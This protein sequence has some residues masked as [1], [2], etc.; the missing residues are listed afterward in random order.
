MWV[1]AHR[2]ACK[3][4]PEN[5]LDAFQVAID[6]GA[7][8]V[9]FD[10]YQVE[11]RTIVIHD[12]WLERTT[13]GSG[14]VTAQSV[15]Y[16]RSLNAGNNEKIPFLAEVMA[17]MPSHAICNIEI[18]HLVDIN[19]WLKELDIALNQSSLNPSNLIISSFNHAWLKKLKAARPALQIGALTATYPENGP[20]FATSLQAY[21]LHM[22]LDVI[23]EGYVK[24]AQDAGLK[25]LVY[26]VDKPDDMRLLAKWGADG[27]FTNVPDIAKA[28][29]ANQ[30][31]S[32]Y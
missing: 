15:E 30:V 21:S 14:L 16:L 7:T 11:G 8:G 27:I 6:F 5:T 4:A 13:N 19:A 31:D 25:V 10:T 3:V 32:P 18:K 17:L 2:G 29:L 26:T 1:I 22:D 23:D 28:V 12:R 9:E 24:D 20:I